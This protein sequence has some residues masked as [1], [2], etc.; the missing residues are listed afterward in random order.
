MEPASHLPVLL[1]EVLSLF[2]GRS[3]RFFFEGTV[4]GGGHAEAIL[5]AHP[6]IECYM[7]CDR[8]PAA[9]QLA[10]SRLARWEQKIEWIEGP[11]SQV[12][13]YLEARGLSSVDGV[14]FDLGVSSMQLDT[15]ERGFSFRF[16]APLDMRMNPASLWTAERVINEFS[17]EELV[18]IFRT[19][20]EEPRAAA[21]ARAIVEARRSRRLSSTTQLLSVISR[22]LHRRGKIHPA[23]RIFQALRIVVNDELGELE[24]GLKGAIAH[25]AAGGRVA[26]ISFHSLEDRI[27]KWR[28]KE[29]ESLEILT[30]K[31]LGASVGERR[32]NPRSRSAK[33][34]AAE[35]RS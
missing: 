31:P 16:G 3:I 27:V 9:L 1:T 26:V 4:G 19:Y 23:T 33:L 29:E 11:F 34:R 12:G 8:D 2:A 5:I 20:G 32:L 28:L 14:L 13:S 25:L 15:P 35:K 7:A 10:R 17:Q 30:K 24:R 21:V 18:H 6:E 22:V